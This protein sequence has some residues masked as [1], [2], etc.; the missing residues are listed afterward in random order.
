MGRQRAGSLSS[1]RLRN[2]KQYKDLPEEEFEEMVDRKKLSIDINNEFERRIQRKIDS[3][4]E[5]YDLSDLKANDI[6]TLRALAQ[7]YI[8]L[9]DLETYLYTLRSEGLNPDIIFSTEKINS[10]ASAL[11]KDIS[12]MQV[13]LSITRK[14]RKGDKEA[15]VIEEIEFLKSKAKEFYKERMFYV[16]CPQCKMLLFTGWFLYPERKDNKIQLVCNRKLEDDKICGHKTIISSREL[17]E[18]RGVNIDDIPET[19]K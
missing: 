15:S 17:M 16:W 9:E 18:K 4:G 6:L 2:L 8:Q 19:F 7:S 11:R 3:F 12:S 1:T 5:D 10:I 14:A 13:D